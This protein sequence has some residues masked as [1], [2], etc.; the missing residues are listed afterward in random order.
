VGNP[1]ENLC[2]TR[3]ESSGGWRTIAA[4]PARKKTTRNADATAAPRGGD[5]DTAPGG[6]QRVGYA[7][8]STFVPKTL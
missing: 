2:A 5:R 8:V 7:R 6:G 1:V 4:M 3:A